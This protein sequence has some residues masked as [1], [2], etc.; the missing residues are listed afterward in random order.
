M[1]PAN[2]IQLFRSESLTGRQRTA[3][4]GANAQRERALSLLLNP[5]STYL[6]ND[7]QFGVEWRELNKKWKEVLRNIAIRRCIPDRNSLLLRSEK[8]P[9]WILEYSFLNGYGI[10]EKRVLKMEFKFGTSTIPSMLDFFSFSANIPFHDLEPKDTYVGYFHE[11]YIP[12]LR[13]IYPEVIPYPPYFEAYTALVFQNNYDRHPFF[14]ALYNAE[15]NGTTE[16]KHKKEVLVKES[17][18]AWLSNTKEKINID[19]ISSI[20]QDSQNDLEYVLYDG[21]S[22]HNE[23]INLRELTIEKLIDIRNGNLLV[24]QSLEPTTQYELLLYW[25]NGDGI[26]WP[27]WTLTIKRNVPVEIKSGA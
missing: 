19:F 14:R 27:A 24:F 21:N 5:N 18:F 2:T 23:Y 10:L 26:L 25:K 22:F 4:E 17:I 11:V 3:N 13:E 15:Q 6:L 20:L 8:P 1:L 9:K 12:K 16:Q 7:G